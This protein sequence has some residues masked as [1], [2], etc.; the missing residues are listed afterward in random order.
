MTLSWSSPTEHRALHINRCVS[1]PCDRHDSSE[2][3]RSG[4]GPESILAKN[5]LRVSFS[6]P[7]VYL[8]LYL[9]KWCRKVHSKTPHMIDTS[10]KMWNFLLLFTSASFFFFNYWFLAVQILWRIRL[11]GRVFCSPLLPWKYVSHACQMC[12]RDHSSSGH[13]TSESFGFS[14]AWESYSWTTFSFLE[15]ISSF[16]WDC[17]SFLHFISSGCQ[18]FAFYEDER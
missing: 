16:D 4:F 5:S 3:E 15:F 13:F 8:P 2:R 10:V 11:S 17:V 1:M 6:L 12:G 14:I 7:S 18:T 9:P